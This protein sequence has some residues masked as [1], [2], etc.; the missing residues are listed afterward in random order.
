MNSREL[1]E[2]LGFT[3]IEPT[4]TA[5]AIPDT[6]TLAAIISERSEKLGKSPREISEATG[7]P[8]PEVSTLA[9]E[10]TGDIGAARKVLR[11][12]GVRPVTMPHP[13]TM[14]GPET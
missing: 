5:R 8:E 7:V 9:R 6:R 2:S 1:L 14:A 3:I 10:G 11:E 12:L 13:R 4:T